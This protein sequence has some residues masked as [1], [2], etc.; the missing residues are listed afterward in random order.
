MVLGI[1]LEQNFRNLIEHE[2]ELFPPNNPLSLQVVFIQGFFIFNSLSF[3]KYL[4]KFAD[5]EFMIKDTPIDHE[6]EGLAEFEYI[7]LC[8]AEG[9]NETVDF[10]LFCFLHGIIFHSLLYILLL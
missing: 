3:V 6:H 2:D 5:G 10:G 7:S 1:W 9:E 4:A 8:P